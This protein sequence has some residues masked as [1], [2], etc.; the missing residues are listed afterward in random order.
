MRMLDAETLYI[1]DD[2][3]AVVWNALA[4]PCRL[5]ALT[6]IVA[7]E[8]EVPAEADLPADLRALLDDLASQGLV[9]MEGPS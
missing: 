9:R 4:E 2:V 6:E 5:G 1:L 7:D 8:F 3:G